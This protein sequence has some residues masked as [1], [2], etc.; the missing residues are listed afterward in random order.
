[1][2]HIIYQFAA[3]FFSSLAVDLIFFFALRYW[4]IHNSKVKFWLPDEH[5]VL[6]VAGLLT[7]AI[8]PLREPYDIWRGNNTF[9]KSCFDQLSWFMG[10]GCGTWGLY[11]FRYLKVMGRRP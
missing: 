6:M 4:A 3:H 7:A 1:M 5:V 9:I 8:L 2:T 11:R 10:A